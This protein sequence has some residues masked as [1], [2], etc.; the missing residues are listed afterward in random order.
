MEKRA[1]AQAGKFRSPLFCS[2]AFRPVFEDASAM[3]E[4]KDHLIA[5]Q[6]VPPNCAGENSLGCLEMAAQ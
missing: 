6:A 3:C 4:Q 5:K 1:G 2:Q